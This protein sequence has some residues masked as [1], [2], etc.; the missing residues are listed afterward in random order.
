MKRT[1][2]IALTVTGLA[3]AGPLAAHH[4]SPFTEEIE[5]RVPDGALDRHNEAVQDVLDRL[6]DMGLAGSMG[7]SNM[8]QSEMDPADSGAGFTCSD[9]FDTECVPGN[10]DNPSAGMDR[11][12]SVTERE[13]PM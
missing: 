1:L 10:V 9:M 5:G 12:P 2:I 3:L 6:D 13:Q 11:G 4:N 7:G 8:R